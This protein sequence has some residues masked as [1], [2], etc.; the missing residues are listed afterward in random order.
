MIPMDIEPSQLH[1]FLDK[2]PEGTGWARSLEKPMR[3]SDAKKWCQSL[4]VNRA[5]YDHP[6]EFL[7]DWIK[8]EDQGQIGSCAG[9]A[10]TSSGEICRR[11]ELRAK[12]YMQFS[13]M[14]AYRI[15]QEFDG[16]NGDRGST[17]SSGVRYATNHGYAP[18][19]AFPYP[20]QYVSRIPKE[21]RESVFKVENA[22]AIKD[23]QSFLDWVITNQGPIF[24][25][26]RWTQYMDN[27]D[28]VETFLGPQR[29][30]RHGGGHAI[31][32]YGWTTLRS[33]V[34]PILWNSWSQ[35][36]GRQGKKPVS[37]KAI[38]EILSDRMTVAVGYT[39]R[40]SP[41]PEDYSLYDDV[42]SVWRS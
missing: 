28:V 41:Q 18:E 6:A 23:P 11:N 10:N 29:N 36:W 5:T 14:A 12:E 40:R 19:S 39:W 33:N 26:M 21:A 42:R 17:I 8:I 27:Q 34:Y 37:Q 16:I 3:L 24:L 20:R 32:F 30:D 4:A 35:R 7:P 15:A 1:K 38:S 22:V 2:D 13:G 9:M 31:F 25:G